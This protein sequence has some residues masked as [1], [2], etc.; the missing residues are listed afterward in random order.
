MA[1]GLINFYSNPDYDRNINQN[2]LNYLKFDGSVEDLKDKINLVSQ[3]D[4]DKLI[5]IINNTQ[6]KA[7]EESI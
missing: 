4:T 7:S 3:L 1:S 6:Q 5:K 2:F